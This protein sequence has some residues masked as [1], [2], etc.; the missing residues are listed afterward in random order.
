MLIPLKLIFPLKIFQRSRMS[1]HRARR[2]LWKLSARLQRKRKSLRRVCQTKS[3]RRSALRWW[4]A[5]RSNWRRTLLRMSIVRTRIHLRGWRKLR[6]YRWVPWIPTVRPE[7]SLHKLIAWVQV[8]RLPG[9]IQRTS[10]PWALH[11]DNSW[12]H[13]WTAAVRRCRRMLETFHL[14]SQFK[15]HKPWRILRVRVWV[16][17][18]QIENFQRVRK[19]SRN[20]RRRCHDLW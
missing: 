2:R 7:G 16:R 20:V 8:R 14:R 1:R 12:S 6:G 19:N 3:L 10:L 18:R 5:V 13:V 4:T 9:G 11:G 17:I 15:V